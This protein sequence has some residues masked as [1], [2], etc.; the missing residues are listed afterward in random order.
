M[1]LALTAAD[2]LTEREPAAA[3]MALMRGALQAT[4]LETRESEAV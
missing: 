4:V 2:R 3:L 1:N